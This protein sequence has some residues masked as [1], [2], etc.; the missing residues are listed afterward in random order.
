VDVGIE[1]PRVIGDLDVDRR[2][3]EVIPFRTAASI[4]RNPPDTTLPLSV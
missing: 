3:T 2:E 4:H 1:F